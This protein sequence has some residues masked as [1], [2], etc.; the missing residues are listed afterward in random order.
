[1]DAKGIKMKTR[2]LLGLV[3][4]IF[5]L[6]AQAAT[7]IKIA[8]VAPDGTAWMREM[9]AGAEAVKKR[10]EGRVEIKYYPGGVMSDEPSVLRK[11]KIGQLQGRAFTGGEFSQTN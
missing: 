5:A 4:G 2:V 1:M 6:G 8:T 7:V 10:S 11:I 9:R 3:L